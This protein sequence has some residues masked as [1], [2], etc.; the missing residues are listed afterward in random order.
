MIAFARLGPER[1]CGAAGLLA[2]QPLRRGFFFWLK[3]ETF[4][5]IAFQDKPLGRSFFTASLSSSSC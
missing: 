1:A 3:I 5:T 2:W 4:R